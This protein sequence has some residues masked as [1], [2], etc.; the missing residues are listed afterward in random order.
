[1]TEVK[2]DR[3][4][5]RIIVHELDHAV[6]A[7]GAAQALSCPLTILSATGAVRSGGA[8]WWRE[9]MS[10]ARAIEPE[11]EAEWILDCA[12]EPGMALGALREG[13]AAICL[14]ADPAIWSRVAQIAAQSGA[15]LL[16]PERT[17]ALD[18]AGSNNPQRDC[19][20]YLSDPADAVA[21]P[22]AL[23]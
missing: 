13:I 11:P 5:G 7:L 1:M 23:G 4:A 12:D 15:T 8:A 6:A 19:K 22:D 3:A 2:C 17:G 10:Q 18:L 9:L 14:D 20:L 21:N 16:R